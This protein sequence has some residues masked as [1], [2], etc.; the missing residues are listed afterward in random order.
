MPDERHFIERRTGPRSYHPIGMQPADGFANV[1]DAVDWLIARGWVRR[2]LQDGE[3][4]L[5]GFGGD[6]GFY[7]RTRAVKTPALILARARVGEPAVIHSFGEFVQH[8]GDAPYSVGAHGT[9][10]EIGPWTWRDELRDIA[11]RLGNRLRRR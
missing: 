8:Y 7:V 3:P 11:R 5:E 2:V 9:P 6:R 10:F 1:G 4:V